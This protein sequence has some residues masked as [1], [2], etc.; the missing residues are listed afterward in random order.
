VIL[1]LQQDILNQRNSEETKNNS[2]IKILKALWTSNQYDED[3]K[4]RFILFLNNLFYIENTEL[5]IKFDQALQTLTGGKITMGIIET[6]QE[7]AREEGIEKGIKKGIK[8]TKLEV[9]KTMKS[10]GY[11][12]EDITKITGLSL[13]EIEALVPIKTKAA[14]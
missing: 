3:V 1:T 14:Q 5:N 7:I 11:P 8:K 9:A 4:R 13:K 12:A 10:Y 6:A 2:R